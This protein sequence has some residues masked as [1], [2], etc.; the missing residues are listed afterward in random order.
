MVRRFRPAKLMAAAAG[1][2]LLLCATGTADAA[3]SADRAPAAQVLV[4]IAYEDA[5]YGGA[6]LSLYGDRCTNP[7][8]PQHINEL[9][10]GWNDQISSIDL[11]GNSR[12]AVI[13]HENTHAG[14]STKSV[15]SDVSNLGGWGDR[16][17]SVSYSY[18][19]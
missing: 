4:A 19:L 1:S 13:L 8:R 18:N 10:Y 7:G 2:V 5:D 14:G 11:V 15:Y 16:A 12:C 3:S 6:Q 9:P 17:S